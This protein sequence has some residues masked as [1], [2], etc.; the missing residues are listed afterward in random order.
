MA[1]NDGVRPMVALDGKRIIPFRN[2]ADNFRL[3]A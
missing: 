3:K 1:K 2:D